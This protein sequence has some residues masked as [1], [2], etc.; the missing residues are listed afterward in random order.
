MTK[1]ARGPSKAKKFAVVENIEIAGIRARMAP[2]GLHLYAESFLAAARAIP[3]QSD[4]PFDPARPYLLCHSIELGLKAF[5]SLHGTAMLDMAENPQ[6]HNL[7]TIL[8]RADEQGLKTASSLTATHRAA[9]RSAEL[10]YSGKLFEYPAVGEALA[11][12]P[13]MPPLDELLRAATILVDELRQS[14]R[15][16]Q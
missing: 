3:P 2:L 15:D 10:Y 9:I 13:G 8:Q 1:T 5:L 12:Y 14:C 11:G 16:A 4:R 6:G 7:G